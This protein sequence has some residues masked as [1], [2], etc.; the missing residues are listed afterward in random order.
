MK[1]HITKNNGRWGYRSLV[2]RTPAAWQ[3]AAAKWCR[4]QNLNEGNL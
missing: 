2:G 4:K 3:K 1:P